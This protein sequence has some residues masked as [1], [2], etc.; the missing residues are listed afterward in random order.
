MGTSGS[1]CSGFILGAAGRE[2]DEKVEEGVVG[3]SVQRLVRGGD[4]RNH[5]VRIDGLPPADFL[6]RL[7]LCFG[8]ATSGVVVELL[9]SPAGL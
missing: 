3:L 1:L 5:W 9:G 7:P 4:S 2:E 8:V 6:L